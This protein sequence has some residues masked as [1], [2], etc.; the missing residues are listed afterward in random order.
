MTDAPVKT[1][2]R[3]SGGS[4]Q[5][6]VVAALALAGF[7]LG[8]TPLAERADL[9]LLDRGFAALRAIAPKPAPDSIVIVGIDEATRRTIAQRHGSWHAPL[10]EAL[11]RIASAR[12]R[13]IALDIL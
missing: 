12:P 9:M 6:L 2:D 4:P 3:H 1:L 13:A 8:Q 5:W 10:G 11:R 7:A